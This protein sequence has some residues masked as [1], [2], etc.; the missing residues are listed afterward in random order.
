MLHWQAEG[1]FAFLLFAKTL[2]FASDGKISNQ[3]ATR[4]PNATACI[5]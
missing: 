5:V 2:I 4:A 3:S 1:V